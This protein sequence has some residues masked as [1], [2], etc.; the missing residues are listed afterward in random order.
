MT[1]GVGRSLLRV[2]GLTAGTEYR[3]RVWTKNLAGTSNT[4]AITTFSTLS[5]SKQ[6]SFI[7]FF[8]RYINFIVF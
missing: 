1:Q 5:N 4:S 7:L 8:R 3:L 2:T 6:S